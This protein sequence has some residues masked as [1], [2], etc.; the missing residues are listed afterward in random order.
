MS[1]G[2]IVLSTLKLTSLFAP[3]QVL[4]LGPCEGSSRDVVERAGPMA[5][6]FTNACFV[7]PPYA[8]IHRFRIN[9]ACQSQRHYVDPSRKGQRR[10][11]PYPYPS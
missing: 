1:V 9:T 6:S 3:I 10:K 8:H 4:L 2:D 5:R 7:Q 11:S